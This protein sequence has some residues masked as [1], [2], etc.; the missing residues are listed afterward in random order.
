MSYF[1]FHHPLIAD[2]PR[3]GRYPMDSVGTLVDLA[4]R[5]LRNT[6]FAVPADGLAPNTLGSNVDPCPFAAPLAVI[7][8]FCKLDKRGGKFYIP[9]GTS[10]LAHSVS[11]GDVVFY[12]HLHTSSRQ[13]VELYVD[14]VLVVERTPDL[15]TAPPGIPRKVN[16]FVTGP[17][18]ATALLGS[19]LAIPSTELWSR[20][21]QMDVWNM[22]LIDVLPHS[23]HEHTAYRPHRIIVGAVAPDGSE[24]VALD[25]RSTSYVPLITD[26]L[27][28]PMLTAS[29]ASTA[30]W[31]DL[32]SWVA[33]NPRMAIGNKPPTSMG[34]SLG[35]AIYDEIR[36]LSGNGFFRGH[37]ALPPLQF[38]GGFA[39]PYHG[40]G[41][42]APL[43]GRMAHH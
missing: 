10:N 31:R 24:R 21:Q 28:P 33:A 12:G 34:T 40:G 19:S 18:F 4:G 20:L 39:N 14:T 3:P 43:T 8:T 17:A 11:P 5:V 9:P 6:R 38:V 23:Y 36:A 7:H 16:H 27:S 42:Q 32:R 13:P 26:S 29:T 15:P 25:A 2:P 41:N 37:V 35:D 22:N 1:F 30:L